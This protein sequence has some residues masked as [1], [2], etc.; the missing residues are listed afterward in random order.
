MTTDGLNRPFSS[1]KTS[2]T[3][4]GPVPTW[5]KKLP[6]VIES[7]AF[8][9]SVAASFAAS[10]HSCYPFNVRICTLLRRLFFG[11]VWFA[12]RWRHHAAQEWRQK[13][14]NIKVWILR[15]IPVDSCEV[16]H[17]H[18]KRGL[19]TF[20]IATTSSWVQRFSAIFSS[21]VAIIFIWRETLSI[22]LLML[23]RSSTSCMVSSFSSRN[24]RRRT[25]LSIFDWRRLILLFFNLFHQRVMVV[26][27]TFRNSC[28][29]CS[30]SITAHTHP[31]K[32][33]RRWEQPRLAV[34]WFE[35][36]RADAIFLQALWKISSQHEHR[37]A[38]LRWVGPL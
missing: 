37:N 32:Y 5:C 14:I 27:A 21:L 38:S 3:E 28:R 36:C 2:S 34:W 7:F 24:A 17:C 31:T 35:E 15:F 13:R 29:A 22:L 16:S 23:W 9:S 25:C 33:G 11:F 18:V 12:C 20:S 30:R 26:T 19:H 8:D 10:S 6:P 1:H 4:V